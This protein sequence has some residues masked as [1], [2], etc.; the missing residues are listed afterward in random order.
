MIIA[1]LHGAGK[2]YQAGGSELVALHPTDLTI[3]TGEL[4]LIIGPSGSGKTTLLSML[5]CVIKPTQG[6]VMVDQQA[7]NSLNADQLAKLR[8][9]TIGFVFQQF[10]L[11]APLNALNNVEMP[12]M[13]QGV[14]AKLARERALTALEKVGMSA[15]KDQKPSQMSGGQQ[16]RVAIARALVTGPQLVLCDEPTASLDSASMVIVMKELQDLARNGKAV[17][18]V[19]HD[20]RLHP[21]ADRAV[22]VENGHVTLLDLNAPNALTA[23]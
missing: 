9:N 13:L 19:T 7:V 4:L 14:P 22:Q 12:M 16:Q 11:L 2:T 21:Y 3:R 5:G 20:P 6:D 17:A 23:Q 10:N 1:Q 15:S 8:L 18:V